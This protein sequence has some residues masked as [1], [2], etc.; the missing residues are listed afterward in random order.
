MH[1]LQF[2]KEDRYSIG[3]QKH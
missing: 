2:R 1:T 3:C